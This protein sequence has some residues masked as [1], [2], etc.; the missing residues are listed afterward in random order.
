MKHTPGPWEV[1]K[2]PAGE[3]YVKAKMP[4]VFKCKDPI[5]FFTVPNNQN[6]RFRLNSKGELWGEIA[7]TQWF[8][9]APEGWYDTQEANAHL[10]AAAPDLLEACDVAFGLITKRDSNTEADYE[11]VAEMLKQAIKKA[12]E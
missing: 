7:Y 9:F 8:Q 2:V 10:M 5:S 6:I 11:E 3:T 1:D 12:K 4:D